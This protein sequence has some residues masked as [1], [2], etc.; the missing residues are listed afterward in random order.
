MAWY[1]EIESDIALGLFH[2]YLANINQRILGRL[3]NFWGMVNRLKEEAKGD[4]V[5]VRFPAAFQ[6]STADGRLAE[7]LVSFCRSVDGLATARIINDEYL[8][9]S[10]DALGK[11]ADR[12]TGTFNALGERLVAQENAAGRGVHNLLVGLGRLADEASRVLQQHWAA[13]VPLRDRLVALRRHEKQKLDGV[14]SGHR[15]GNYTLYEPAIDGEPILLVSSGLDV[16][17]TAAWDTEAQ[18]L[19][20]QAAPAQT[21]QGKFRQRGAFKDD[22]D[23]EPLPG[24][25]ADER[26]FR[27]A[28]QAAGC[29]DRTVAV[30]PS[31]TIL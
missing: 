6:A 8:A 10:A 5:K 1:K 22:I 24:H 12:N 29:K 31:G 25:G 21:K 16:A 26:L 7:V 2:R 9:R 15:K 13:Y 14:I 27:N 4:G 19:L 23:F 3:L 18:A 20:S 28:L 30:V 11:P 17:V